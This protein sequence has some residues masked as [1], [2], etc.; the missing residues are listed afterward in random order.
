VLRLDPPTT[1]DPIYKRPRYT[2]SDGS[3]GVFNQ[4]LAPLVKG[5]WAIPGQAPLQARGRGDRVLWGAD[6][7]AF[8]LRHD[9]FKTG[10]PSQPN[11]GY[12]AINGLNYSLAHYELNQPGSYKIV[13]FTQA[14]K[15]LKKR[16]VTEISR[17]TIEAVTDF[18]EDF[19]Q[20]ELTQNEPVEP[21]IQLDKELP[22]GL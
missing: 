22:D 11:K 3:G 16:D 15:A 7:N 8:V 13:T 6:K 20:N 9:Y 21:P 10:N 1:A 19:V 14:L 4:V 18:I 2:P 12:K 5:Q 17:L